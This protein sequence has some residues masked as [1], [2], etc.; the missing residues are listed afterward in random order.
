VYKK[1]S[2]LTFWLS[3]LPV[4][5]S[6]QQAP[7]GTTASVVMKEGKVYKQGD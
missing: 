3:L 2:F 4:L 1:I 5:C 6:A 7:V